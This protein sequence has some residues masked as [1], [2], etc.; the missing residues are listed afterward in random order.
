MSP[1]LSLEEI[2]AIAR[3]VNSAEALAREHVAQEPAV[4]HTLACVLAAR[5][6]DRS[7]RRAG[8]TATLALYDRL[9]AQLWK[10]NQ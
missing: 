2:A 4:E 10:L 5:L 7:L 8:D 9:G 6:L 3:I 1:P